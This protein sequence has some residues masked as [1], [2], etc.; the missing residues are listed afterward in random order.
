VSDRAGHERHSHDRAD[1]GGE[2]ARA[3]QHVSFHRA[4]R[5]R[6]GAL[7]EAAVI[8]T[9]DGFAVAEAPFDFEVLVAEDNA[10]NQ[11]LV[12]RFL[13]KLG[14]RTT[15][16]DNGRAALRAL[17]RAAF[18]VVLMDVQMP[19]MDGYAASAAIR[20][21]RD[22]AI[23][24]LPIVALTAHA[25]P[26]D[27]ER[28]LAAGMDGFLTKPLRIDALRDELRRVAPRLLQASAQRRTRL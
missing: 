4:L 2:R 12:E 20:A 27:R 22:P 24:A 8:A 11:M 21:H 16:A 10:V 7:D 9:A 5:Q 14:C 1:L 23:A 15:V 17:E 28:C 13:R 26:A 18:D 19:E 6:G 25:M 3:R